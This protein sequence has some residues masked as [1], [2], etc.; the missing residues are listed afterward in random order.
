M[1]RATV[2]LP[3]GEISLSK[4]FVQGQAYVALSRIT[5]LSGV[6]VLPGFDLKLPP[7][8]K[9]VQQFYKEGVVPVDAV[10]C[11][12]NIP[13]RMVTA[14]QPEESLN[15][16]QDGKAEPAIAN[17]WKHIL[18]L[19][20]TVKVDQLL[21]G[22]VD[23]KMNSQETKSLLMDIGFGKKTV[24]PMLLN[25][26]CHSWMKLDKLVTRPT[27][28]EVVV[29]LKKNWVGYAGALHKLKISRDL[30]NRWIEVLISSKVSVGER[31]LNS[32]QRSAMVRLLDRLHA[33]LIGK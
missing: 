21:H 2:T 12:N 30:S 11:L 14:D 15:K 16:I 33:M 23:D 18:P 10:N 6:H 24:P 25:F 4:L 19:P 32:V 9:C 20:A 28:D 1:S 13:I 8:S 29:V 22:M 17:D 3:K 31:I 5:T 27:T 7:V 26:I